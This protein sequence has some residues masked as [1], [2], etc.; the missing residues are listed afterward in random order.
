M[1]SIKKSFIDAYFQDYSV[2]ELI[3]GRMLK[4]TGHGE[5][6]QLVLIAVHL[7]PGLPDDEPKEH[8]DAIQNNFDSTPSR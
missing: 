2:V 6:G 3:N 4:F 1:L 7:T 8:L 5:Q